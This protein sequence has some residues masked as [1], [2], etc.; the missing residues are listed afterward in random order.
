MKKNVMMRVASALLV[1]VLLTTCSIS[2]TFAKYVTQDD[3]SDAARVAKWGILLQ[4]D[5]KLYGDNYGTG[6][7]SI[8]T[9]DT[10]VANL[11]V[12]ADAKAVAPGTQN[13]KGLNFSINGTPE[14][15]TKLSAT[16]TCQ[17]IYLAEGKYA[18]MVEA[19]TVTATSW[20]EDTYYTLSGSTYAL[21]TSWADTTYY[22]MEDVVDLTV[23]YYYPVVY[24]ST[25]L[26]TGTIA[27]DSL[28]AI[29]ADYAKK[30]NNNVAVT[31]SETNNIYTYTITN[32][33][34][35]PNYNYASLGV[36]GENLTW[37]WAF[38]QTTNA[39]MYNGAD[40]ILANLQAGAAVIDVDT[41]TAPIE[42][43]DYNLE[44]AFS[45]NI[46]VEQVD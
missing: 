5:G 39:T 2:G 8:P 3:A 34:K 15:R 33:I 27:S 1:A 36:A 21:S 25:D 26:D 7:N 14:V 45:I 44:T 29:A 24:K 16:I 40:T 32:M 6:T 23:E 11:S 28:K 30:L 38:E 31:E 43:T 18:V 46:T 10:S 41:L 13:D 4:A 12:D 19:P 42:H 37:A 22:T 35:E 17:N 20:V 9:T